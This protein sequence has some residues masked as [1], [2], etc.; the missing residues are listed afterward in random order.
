MFQFVLGHSCSSSPPHSPWQPNRGSSLHSP[1]PVLRSHGD[2]EAAEAGVV[3]KNITPAVERPGQEHHFY[4]IKYLKY[5]TWMIQWFKWTT[6]Q[7]FITSWEH[8]N[9]SKFRKESLEM[10]D[11]DDTHSDEWFWWQCFKR[12]FLQCSALIVVISANNSVTAFIPS[13]VVLCMPPTPKFINLARHVEPG[14][15]ND[16]HNIHQ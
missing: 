7:T 5:Q 2:T 11:D 16:D 6:I 12:W 3:L 15:V 1:L 14:P 4:T 10:F 8:W 9:L 13:E